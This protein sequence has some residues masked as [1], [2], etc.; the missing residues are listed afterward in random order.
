M[1]PIESLLRGRTQWDMKM[2]YSHSISMARVM[3]PKMNSCIRAMR[4]PILTR[5]M[6]GLI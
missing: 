3:P 4:P 1:S 5:A 6:I 2:G